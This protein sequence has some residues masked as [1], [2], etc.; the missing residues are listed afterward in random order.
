MYKYLHIALCSV[1]SAAGTGG[2]L[3][4]SHT[5]AASH[6]EETPA[7]AHEEHATHEVH[8]SYDGEGAPSHWAELDQANKMCDMGATQSPVDLTPT[9]SGDRG[10]PVK[11]AYKPSRVMMVN[12]GH[13]VQYNY[14]PGSYLTVGGKRYEAL[15]MH[16]HAASEHT[17][18]GVRYPLEAHIVHKADDGSLAVLG[19]LFKKGKENE[20]LREADW[21]QMPRAAEEEYLSDAELDLAALVPGGA[22]WRYGGSLTTPPCTE[23]VAWHVY[24][25]VL[26]VSGEQLK[27]FTELYDH[28]FRPTQERKPTAIASRH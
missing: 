5:Y 17:V 6:A 27:V 25:K 9:Q 23:G 3:H 1:L 24:E 10:A 14:E 2:V 28:N 8:W 4:L 12:N 26:S 21:A 7:K 18:N 15:Q 11:L 13:T 16:F 19:I 22:M 20:I